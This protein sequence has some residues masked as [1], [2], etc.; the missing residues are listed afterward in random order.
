[1]ALCAVL[2]YAGCTKKADPTPEEIGYTYFPLDIGSYRIYNVT[3]INW[4]NNES[5]TTYYQ[6]QE[7]IDT[8]FY[9]QSGQLTYKMIRSMRTDTTKNWRDDSVITVTR[10]SSALTVNRNNI[11]KV[12]MVF[13]VRKNRKW[14]TNEFN[15]LGQEEISYSVVGE[16][17]TV[18]NQQYPKTLTVLES[19][20]KNIVELDQR[21]EVYANH[22]GLIFRDY[23]QYTYCNDPT[24]CNFGVDEILVGSQ[25]IY[26]L[27][28]HGQK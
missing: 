10:T 19:D 16:P 12:K 20:I 3:E 5:D 8:S 9:D 1:M 2:A 21:K 11:S 14:N 13:P 4:L 18:N 22:I 24:K 17:F 26:E 28:S 7:R 27:E 6:I 23:K 15:N 25:L